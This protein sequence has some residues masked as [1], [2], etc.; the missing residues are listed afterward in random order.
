MGTP[1]AALGL[2]VIAV[3]LI[4]GGCTTSETTPAPSVEQS[5]PTPSISDPASGEPSDGTPAT[6]FTESTLMTEVMGSPVFEGF[7]HAI[8]PSSERITPDMTISDV[9]WL[10][11]YHSNVSSADVTQ[12]L[13]TM[14]SEVEN[15]TLTWHPVYS[16]DE[17]AA[18][19]GKADVGLFYFAERPGA[20]FAII[21][22]GGGFSYVG[23]VHEG[24]PYAHAIT[25]RG[26]NAFVLNYRTGEGGRLA[27]ED[28]ARA[29]DYILTNADTLTVGTDNYSLW[30][31]SAG[32]RMAANLG[33][34]GTSAFG[35]PDHPRATTVVMAYTGHSDYTADEPA[36]FA[37]VGSN[38]GIANPTTMEARI[39][40]LRDAGIPTQF[41]LYQG[42]GH[43][44]GL[45]TGTA[46]DGWIDRA[47]S[48]WEAQMD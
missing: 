12:T 44:F 23:S 17:I 3:A 27:S 16:D 43:G 39:D 19:P 4:L 13:N 10:L 28:L 37:V 22:S 21:N 14:A 36:T 2:I 29:I 15:G 5:S 38:D 46:A 31:S 47:I 45:G 25:A 40:A 9:S 30:G 35:A 26:Y 42:I 18:D 32:A 41:D 11:P 7:G 1:K 6:P 48:F 24:F 20:P 33:G 8:F 34:Y